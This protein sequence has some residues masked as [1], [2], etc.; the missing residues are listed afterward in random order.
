MNVIENIFSGEVVYKNT[1]M[2]VVHDFGGY[3]LK[4][5]KE[6]KNNE[7]AQVLVYLGLHI[8]E[9]ICF[10]N[11][12]FEEIIKGANSAFVKLMDS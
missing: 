2:Q 9:L 12:N 10:L 1:S 7:F 4:L 6:I 5:I 11:Y 3:V 8:W